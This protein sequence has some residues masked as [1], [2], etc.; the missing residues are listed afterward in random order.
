MNAI[1]IGM[2]LLRPTLVAGALALLGLAS[3]ATPVRAQAPTC[4]RV[5]LSALATQFVEALAAFDG[6]LLPE[7]VPADLPWASR[8]RF[9][10]ND[11]G[12]MIGEGLWGT[13]TAVGEG[14]LIA[15]PGSGNVLWLGIVEEHGQPAYLALR[16]KV[17]GRAI[18]E[19]EAIVGREGTPTW[20]AA[21]EGYALSR[22]FSRTLP[23]DERLPRAR[24]EALVDGY[25]SSMQLNDGTVQTAI[26]DECE[27]L[28]N[29][30]STTHADG[31][32]VTGCRE[33]L[34]LGWYRHVDRVRARRFPIVDEARGVVVAI[35]YLDH[36]ARY[37]EYETLDGV[38][39]TIPVEYPNSHAVL[40]VFRIEDGRISRI[41]GVTA[42]Q[43]YLMPTQW[44]P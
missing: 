6:T 9:T 31:I 14:T 8:V 18:A 40:E 37:V 4:D 44:V 43:P 1:R 15:D 25:Y 23:E 26:A 34:E 29:G 5:C 35:A 17:E 11:V 28:T 30:Y 42:F 38:T 16:L 33:Q 12:L 3:L 7:P 20:F 32:D 27:R 19:A 22:D 36:A 13:V 2:R 41:E 21:T 10:E 24:L 39:R